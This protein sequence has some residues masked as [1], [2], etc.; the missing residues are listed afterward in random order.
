MY[1]CNNCWNEA[2]KWQWQC[3]FCKEW[4]TL[5]EFRESKNSSKEAWVKKNLSKLENSDKKEERIITKSEELNNVLWWWIVPWSL[6]LLSGEPGIWKSTLSLQLANFI[7]KQIIY[8][9]GEET[10][11]QLTSR[12]NR[13]WVS[14]E[15]LSILCENNLENIFESIKW[16]YPEILI[17]DSISVLNSSQSSGWSG[18]ISQVKYIS[19]QLQDFAKSNNI[20]TIIIWHV[21]KDWNLAWPKLLEHLVDTVL[22]FEWERF[23]DIRILRSIKNRFGTTNEVAIYKMEETGLKDLKNPWMELIDNKE[24]TP[25]IWSSLSITLEWTRPILI[26]CEALTNYTKF[27]YPKRSVRWVNTSKLDMLAAILSKYTKVKLDSSDVYLNIARWL[28]IEDPAIDLWLVSAII[29]SKQN[30]AVDRESIFI[31]E[32]SLTW[33]IK[34]VIQL[35]KR[36]KEAEKLGFKKIY[37]PNIDLKWDFKIEIVKV[38]SIG[39]FV[40]KIT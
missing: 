11:W 33:T 37:V 30:K 14:G 7:D 23:E 3:S 10:I 21:T 19:E 36:I 40:E 22:F 25:I 31:W 15:K 17:V 27:G 16:N 18:S 32:I 6:I 20:T 38:K 9:S 2:I 26:E 4:N 1:I 35:E 39:E 24:K 12:A 13:L 8:V 29:S 5:V 28:K 34:N